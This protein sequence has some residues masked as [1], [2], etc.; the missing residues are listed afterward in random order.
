M[1]AQLPVS[2]IVSIGVRALVKPAIITGPGGEKTSV[3][4]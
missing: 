3:L 2:V 1:Y 4:A